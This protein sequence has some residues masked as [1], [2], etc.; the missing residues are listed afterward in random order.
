MAFQLQDGFNLGFLE[1]RRER[2]SGVG[3]N[4]HRCRASALGALEPRAAAAHQELLATGQQ[5]ACHGDNHYSREDAESL[6]PD[7]R[8]LLFSM[9]ELNI[10]RL[11]SHSPGS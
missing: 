1:D 9:A 4:Q 6:T 8:R 10:V 5:I 11:S 3:V 7:H 2:R